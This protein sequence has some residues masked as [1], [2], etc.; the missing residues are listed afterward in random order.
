MSAAD[1]AAIERLLQDFGLGDEALAALNALGAALRERA[2]ESLQATRGESTLAAAASPFFLPLLP[3]AMSETQRAL[4]NALAA[5]TLAR[6]SL[7]RL[8]AA[9]AETLSP[10]ETQERA[11]R[12]CL[13]LQDLL[14]AGAL[15]VHAQDAVRC[16]AALAAAEHLCTAQ[17]ALLAAAA[18]NG[19]ERGDGASGQAA[20]TAKLDA[21]IAARLAD[22]Q[23]LALLYVDCGVI[24]RID[25]VWG[26]LVGDAVRERLAAR[27]RSE[28][29][30]DHDLLG[31]PGRDAFACVLTTLQSAGVALLAAE[32]V[33][34]TL[35]APLWVDVH[36]VFARP[37]VGIALY[38]EH[39]DN[40]VA[41]LQRA[42]AASVAARDRPERFALYSA[43]Q[44]RDE[45]E[46]LLYENR[47]RAA[48]AQDALDIVFQP[49]RDLRSNLLV[50]A[51]S[52]L[53]W[54]D[55][56]LGAVPVEKAIAVA[57][58][59]GLVNE[60]TLW[61]VNGALRN[62]RQFRDAAGLDLRIAVKLS[63][64]SLRQSDLPDFVASALK[65]WN[66]RPSRLALEITETAVLARSLESVETLQKLRSTGVRLCLD[67]ASAG[68]HSL[69]WLATLPFH[70]L[71]ID[72]AA[73]GNIAEVPQKLALVR[74]L[75]ELAHQLK[76]EVVVAGVE[77]AATAALLGPLGCDIAQGPAIGAPLDAAAFAQ[78]HRSD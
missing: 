13:P 63:A 43:E 44:E 59:A 38:P 58:S 48:I 35:D 24:D 20:L 49:Q 23:Q 3:Q 67:D 45:A 18:R 9:W 64:K 1:A 39:A 31:D 32:K 53:R 55:A 26:Y 75:V 4:V 47:L 33:L 56:R 65:T 69:S 30:R 29:V 11:R 40:A 46:L 6:D 15:G 36:E 21:F 68:Y 27:L 2:P 50:G 72:L 71:K 22:G 10:E 62:C 77:D 60:V 73:V 19:A 74:S 37:A 41:L 51:E 25:D 8:L 54:R 70:E 78:R 34:R 52:Q 14:R 57:E 76:L 17:M 28:V 7:R 42:R 61:M 12:D 16:E 5:G 66:L